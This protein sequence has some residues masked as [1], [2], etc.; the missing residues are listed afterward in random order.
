MLAFYEHAKALHESQEMGCQLLT[1]W[2]EGIG[3]E[4]F[5]DDGVFAAPSHW[6]IAYVRSRARWSTPPKSIV[7]SVG[8][9]SIGGVA[10]LNVLITVDGEGEVVEVLPLPV[11]DP[12][13]W[14]SSRE[15]SALGRQRV[16]HRRYS[17]HTASPLSIAPAPPFL[18]RSQC[19]TPSL[20]SSPPRHAPLS[21]RRAPRAD[22]D[23]AAGAARALRDER[24]HS[25][26]AAAVRARR[27]RAPRGS[28]ALMMSSAAQMQGAVGDATEL[29]HRIQP[30]LPMSRTM[31]RGVCLRCRAAGTG[32]VRP[33]VPVGRTSRPEKISRACITPPPNCLTLL[34]VGHLC[35]TNSLLA[36]RHAV[37]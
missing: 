35:P 8:V 24:P 36:S 27:G 19:T 4:G 5:V 21:P 11:S 31:L 14:R 33:D 32:P 10:E 3:P 9:F 29:A 23:S 22:A 37:R 1:L 12:R 18:G 30:S 16:A 13:Q 7:N 34:L 25:D 20:A 15:A 6:T 17:R 26:L 28:P 2:G